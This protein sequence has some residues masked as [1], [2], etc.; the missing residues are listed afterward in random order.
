MNSKQV[1]IKIVPLFSPLT[2]QGKL[3]QWSASAS[4]TKV[5][6]T[7]KIVNVFNVALFPWPLPETVPALYAIT[8]QQTNGINRNCKNIKVMENVVFY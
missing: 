7:C 2:K 8:N 5:H 6:G 1:G 3:N 4:F